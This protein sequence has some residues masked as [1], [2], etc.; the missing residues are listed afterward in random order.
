MPRQAVS[1]NILQDYGEPVGVLAGL[2]SVGADCVGG[3]GLQLLP[4]GGGGR[5]QFASVLTAGRLAVV[6]GAAWL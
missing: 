6:C 4:G 5:R 1:G 2:G 3:R